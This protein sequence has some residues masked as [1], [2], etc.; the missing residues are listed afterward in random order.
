M[1]TAFTDYPLN[2]STGVIEV[3]VLAYD[4]NKYVTVRHGETLESVK[5]GYLYRDVQLRHWFGESWLYALPEEV[6]GPVPTRK[7]VHAEL[8]AIRRRHRT[9]YT[10]WVGDKKHPYG[11]LKA[12]LRH[13]GRVFRDQDC[14][15]SRQQEVRHS[16]RQDSIVESEGGGLVI[17]V[18]GRKKTS[19]FRSRHR[20]IA[21]F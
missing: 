13:F 3:T 14:A 6:G 4:R 21:G 12:A 5:S 8:R 19:I 16:W 7:A 17:P 10:L 9:T 1:R 2:G 15:L 18:W 20:R 11:T